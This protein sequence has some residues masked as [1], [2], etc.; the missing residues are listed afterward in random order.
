MR[1]LFLRVLIGVQ[2]AV[3]LY[4]GLAL[5]LISRDIAPRRVDLLTRCMAGHVAY[6]ELRLAGTRGPAR[7][8]RLVALQ[9]ELPFAPRLVSE[10]PAGVRADLAARGSAVDEVWD[11][12]VYYH[13]LGSGEVLAL[14]PLQRIVRLRPALI[15]SLLVGMAVVVGLVGVLLATPVVRNLR[16][17]ER[18]VEG[19]GRGAFDGRARVRGRSAVA[20]LAQG[21]DRMADQIE[22]MVVGQRRLFAV[23]SH[24]LRTPPAR[25]RFALDLL[26]EAGD[27]DE[28]QAHVRSI[29]EDLTEIDQLVDE[30]LTY[31]R[32]ETDAPPL[33]PEVFDPAE[34]VRALAGRTNGLG[35]GLAGA[36]DGEPDIEVEVRADPG[37]EVL[38]NRKYFRRAIEN[39]LTNALR[40]ARTRVRIDV[41]AD[42]G[43]VSV[44]VADDG[45]GVPADARERIFEPFAS[46]DESRSKRL[47]G[48]GLGLA[49]V[50]RIMAWHGGRVTVGDADLGG[51]RFATWWPRAAGA[52]WRG[53]RG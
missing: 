31:L 28:R 45:A 12:T 27:A 17:L 42:E 16:I 13:V 34:V 15:A 4:F 37:L 25:I 2:L 24:E 9:A 29:D 5:F 23:V 44:S 26:A 32:L 51:A 39:L 19:F 48:I 46:L 41:A 18:A 10:P 20:R 35:G 30:L 8:A 7:D 6:S 22:R 49:I 38:A 40:H 33:E 47:G 50:T 43:G 11:G 53:A 1:Q 52:T 36:R 21:F 14:G 3:V